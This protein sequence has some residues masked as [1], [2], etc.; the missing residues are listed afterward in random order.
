MILISMF[1]EHALLNVKVSKSLKK[2][3]A[4]EAK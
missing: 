2:K 4:M 3:N 1:D